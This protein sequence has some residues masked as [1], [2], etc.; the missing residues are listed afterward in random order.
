MDNTKKSILVVEDEPEVLEINVRL[1]ERRGFEVMTA[2]DCAQAY[3]CL[4]YTVPDL[5]ILDIML[6]DGSGYDICEKFRSESNNPVIFLT[7]KDEIAD[8][9]MGLDRG[10]D[11]YLTKPY[12]FDELLAVV[13]MLFERLDRSEGK[14]EQPA[15]LIKGSLTV[16]AAQGKAFINGVDVALTMKEFAL[17]FLLIKNENKVLSPNELYEKVWGT[18]SVADTRVV[19]FHIGNLKKKINTKESLDYDIMSAYGKGYYFTS[20]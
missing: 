18:A 5:L 20:G 6:P 4:K 1:L 14:K 19:R 15:V 17:L 9:I 16:D 11:Y 2:A 10:G 8:K 7:G 3:E 13:R 12:S